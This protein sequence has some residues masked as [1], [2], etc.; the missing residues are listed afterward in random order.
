MGQVIRF[1]PNMRQT[2]IRDM[3]SPT[4]ICYSHKFSFINFLFN[5][6][7]SYIFRIENLYLLLS[8]IFF[9]WKLSR[10]NTV[11]RSLNTKHWFVGHLDFCRDINNANRTRENR[12]GC[13]FLRTWM[14]FWDLS[15]AMV[16]C[17]M[18]PVKYYILHGFCF[19]YSHAD[20]VC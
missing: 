2:S 14:S 15:V 19:F 4:S 1:R 20:S 11:G 5:P 9:E 7:W 13:A 18:R 8:L 3:L 10:V 17:H 6:V 16:Y 12:S